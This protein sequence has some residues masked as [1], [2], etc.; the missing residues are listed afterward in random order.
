MNRY[1]FALGRKPVVEEVPAVPSRE[2]LM[3]MLSHHK[4]IDFPCLRRKLAKPELWPETS[5]EQMIPVQPMS[6]PMPGISGPYTFSIESTPNIDT[7]IYR[8]FQ[9]WMSRV[10]PQPPGPEK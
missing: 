5:A 6:G 9:D 2:R 10:N 7:D 1:D 4:Q 8:F 3:E